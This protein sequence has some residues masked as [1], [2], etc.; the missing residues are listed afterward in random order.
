MATP[1]SGRETIIGAVKGATWGVPLAAGAN[2]ALLPLASGVGRGFQLLEDRSLGGAWELDAQRGVI[3]AGGPLN[4]FLRYDN[5]EWLL[6]A[7]LM[8]TAGA[9]V[10]Q[11][12]TTAYLHTLQLADGVAGKFATLAKKMKSDEVWEF[13]SIKPVSL[14]LTGGKRV[15]VEYAIETVASHKNRNAGS[16]TNNTTTI[17]TITARETLRRIVPQESGYLRINDQSAGALGTGDVHAVSTFELMFARPQQGDNVLD[18]NAFITEPVGTDFA[19][20]E[21]VATFPVYEDKADVLLDKF[22][23]DTVQ[24]I[25]LFADSGAILAGTAIPYSLKIQMPQA[26]VVGRPEIAIAGPGKIVA[27]IRF[28]LTKASAAPAGMTGVTN[29]FAMLLINKRTTDILA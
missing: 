6:I 25:E 20:S 29:P 9:P 10:Q 22:E 21:F 26:Q 2:H 13:P 12:A 7:L 1:I 19:T 15:P 27:T 11:G 24:K 4:G 17:A 18:G 16:G 5:N 3:E 8:G 28:R 23:A 14:R